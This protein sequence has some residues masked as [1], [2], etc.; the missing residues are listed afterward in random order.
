MTPH[1]SGTALEPQR[2]YAKGVRDCLEAYFEG[3]K[4]RP[5]YLIVDDGEITSHSY[6]PAFE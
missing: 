1:D 2:R 6:A 3:E 4:I 5:E